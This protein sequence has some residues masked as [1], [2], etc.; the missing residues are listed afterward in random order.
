MSIQPAIYTLQ[1]PQRAS[2]SEIIRV[3][4]DGTGVTVLA[5]VWNSDKRQRKFLDLSIQ[6]IDRYEEWDPLDSTKIRSTLSI[7]ADWEQTREIKKNGYWDLLW[8][9]EDETRD[10]ILEGPAI[11][12]RNATEQEAP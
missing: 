1:I 9:W 3:P 10:Y 12:N 5:S 8:I 11:V 2:L 4:Y 6:W 7:T